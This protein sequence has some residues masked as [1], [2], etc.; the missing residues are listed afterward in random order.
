MK[1][2][3]DDLKYAQTTGM[4]VQ[5]QLLNGDEM[6]TGVHEVHE[7]EGFVSLYAPQAFGD[8]TTTKKVGLDLIATCTVTNIPYSSN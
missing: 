2:H 8:D 6:L 1:Y 5:I 4:S 3:A 7:D